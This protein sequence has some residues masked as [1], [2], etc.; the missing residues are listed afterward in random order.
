MHG[1]K[2]RA[3]IH[4]DAEGGEAISSFSHSHALQEWTLPDVI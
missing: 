3:S 4:P 2:S 1:Q